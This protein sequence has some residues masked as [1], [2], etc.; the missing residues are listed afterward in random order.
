MEC[1]DCHDPHYQKQKSFKFTDASNLYLATGTITSGVYNGTDNT[2]T[3][4]YSTITYKS[5]WNAVKLTQKTLSYRRTILFPD[6][7][8]LSYNYP[9][10]SID[11]DAKTIKVYLEM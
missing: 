9:I 2:S 11:S 1:R 8:S 5:G 6:A 3:L 4:T 7:S 10:I